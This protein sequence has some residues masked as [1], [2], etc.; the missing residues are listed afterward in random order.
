MKTKLLLFYL[1]LSLHALAQI[2]GNLSVS[3]NVDES[4]PANRKILLALDAFLS[5]KDTASYQEL[6]G[7]WDR[8]DFERFR[9]PYFFLMGM[10]KN[11]AGATAYKPS[12]MEILPIGNDRHIVKLSY[13]STSPANL[14]VKAVC[15]LIARYDKGN[16]LFSSY[17]NLVDGKW[18]EA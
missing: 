6:L 12:V 5:K 1:S 18:R 8:I 4:S 10:E 3:P 15:N 7:Y 13:I 14:F 9:T 16:V 11:G 2:G 17:I